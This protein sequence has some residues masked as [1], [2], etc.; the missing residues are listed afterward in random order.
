MKEVRQNRSLRNR[1]VVAAILAVCAVVLF[2]IEV[3][4]PHPEEVSTRLAEVR[5]TLAGVNET[6]DTLLARYGIE[7]GWIKTWQVQTPNKRF[8]RVERRVFVPGDFISVNFNHDLSRTLAAY[9]A[10]T[11]VGTERTKENTVTLHIKKDNTIIQS[12]SLVTKRDL[13]RGEVRQPRP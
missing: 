13:Q 8:L 2:L 11:V 10:T 5:P 7:K 4:L 3:M 12:I 6:V 1:L 9:G